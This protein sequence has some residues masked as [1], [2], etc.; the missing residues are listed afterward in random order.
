M[1]HGVMDHNII[2]RTYFEIIE[3]YQLIFLRIYQSLDLKIHF[4][5]KLYVRRWA[6]L[7][8]AAIKGN[9]ALIAFASP[10]KIS[11]ILSNIFEIYI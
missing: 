7:A 9:M 8:R 2:P 5:G 6:M 3:S 10:P 1:T 11:N 4:D